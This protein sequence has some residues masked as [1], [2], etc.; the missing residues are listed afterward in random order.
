MLTVAASADAG[1][2]RLHSLAP[3]LPSRKVTARP[4]CRAQVTADLA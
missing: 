3:G 4:S 2:A 1:S